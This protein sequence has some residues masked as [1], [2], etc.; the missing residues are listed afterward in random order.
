MVIHSLCVKS[1]IQEM[2]AQIMLQYSHTPIFFSLHK[3]KNNV[4]KQ[5]KNV[6]HKKME[7]VLLLYYHGLYQI[8]IQLTQFMFVQ[9]VISN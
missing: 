9:I 1:A 2:Q 4:L 3:I 7:Y 8:L 6:H 5:L